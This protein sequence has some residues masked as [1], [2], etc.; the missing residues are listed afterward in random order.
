[1]STHHHIVLTDTKRNLPHFL[2][3]FHRLKALPMKIYRKWEGPLWDHEHASVVELRTPRAIVEKIAYVMANPT[4]VGAV[5]HAKHWP[6]LNTK[7]QDLA[8]GEFK[9]KLPNIYFDKEKGRWPKEATLK[10]EMP[11]SLDEDFIDPIEAIEQEYAQL[12]QAA[13]Q[14]A[15]SE[16]RTFLGVDRVL[17]ISPYKR[18]RSWEDIR[19]RNPVFAVGRGQ[20]EAKEFAVSVLVRF[21]RAYREAIEKWKARIGDVVFPKGTWWMVEFHGVVVS[22]GA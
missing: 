18:A 21:R 12:Q 14:K 15:K 16:G 22:D 19:S 10:L 6:G 1:M 17:K 20:K 4:E 3:D 5:Y 2:R 13:R 8:R 11:G 7:V 9:A